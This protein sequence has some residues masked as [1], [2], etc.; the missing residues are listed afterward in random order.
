MKYKHVQA[1]HELRM[2]IVQVIIPA[3]VFMAAVPE[4][5]QFVSEKFEK[6]KAQI[7]DKLNNR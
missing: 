5:R 4:A 2:W 6:G 1:S 7:K 3:M